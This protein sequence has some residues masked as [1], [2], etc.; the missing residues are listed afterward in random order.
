MKKEII[1]YANIFKNI[2]TGR[3]FVP[4]ALHDSWEE[5]KEAA[6]HIYGPYKYIGTRILII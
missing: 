3:Y 4:Y 6:Q 1:K 5:A 2:E